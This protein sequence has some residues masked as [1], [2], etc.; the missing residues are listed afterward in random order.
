M[1]NLP[2]SLLPSTTDSVTEAPGRNMDSS[3]RKQGLET[4]ETE[5]KHMYRPEYPDLSPPSSTLVT[6]QS[7]KNVHVAM[8]PNGDEIFEHAVLGPTTRDII[9]FLSIIRGKLQAVQEVA[10]ELSNLHSVPYPFQIRFACGL[11][12]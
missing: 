1:L 11:S 3:Q 6:S 9:L 2:F 7:S 5:E 12:T 8:I 10:L 4:V